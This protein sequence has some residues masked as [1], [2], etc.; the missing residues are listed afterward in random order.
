MDYQITTCLN[1]GTCLK[2][3]VGDLHPRNNVI[4]GL[5]LGTHVHFIVLDHWKKWLMTLCTTQ[6]DTVHSDTQPDTEQT[7][8]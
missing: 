4:S 6:S 1:D 5:V 7:S 8:P 3:F 2:L